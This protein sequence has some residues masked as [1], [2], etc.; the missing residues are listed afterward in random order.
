[1]LIQSPKGPS[2]AHLRTLVPKT[3][4]GVWNQIPQMGSIWTLITAMYYIGN[5]AAKL[6]CCAWNER[7]PHV[8]CGIDR[9]VG[10]QKT[11]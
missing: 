9:I 4:P 7:F 2:T 10:P 3:I 1:M 11:T 6:L 8:G 5:S